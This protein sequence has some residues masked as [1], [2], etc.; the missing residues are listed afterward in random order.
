VQ[1]DPIKPVLKAPASK[2]LKLED[3]EMLSNLAFKFSLRRYTKGLLVYW[4]QL[5]G[6]A[7]T[8]AAYGM[9]F[10]VVGIVGGRTHTH[11]MRAMGYFLPGAAAGHGAAAVGAGLAPAVVGGGGK[12]GDERLSRVDVTGK[13]AVKKVQ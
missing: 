4:V 3:E 12:A 10:I 2:L 6:I 11:V 8:S 5:E 7:G 9:G 1:V 13:T